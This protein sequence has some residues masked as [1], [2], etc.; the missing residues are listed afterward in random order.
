MNGY[1]MPKAQKSYNDARNL[2]KNPSEKDCELAIELLD[3]DVC[4][5]HLPKAVRDENYQLFSSA[6]VLRADIWH[7]LLTFNRDK[8]WNT[9][10][11]SRAWKQKCDKVLSRD[12]HKCRECGEPAEKVC[13]KRYDQLGREPLSDLVSRCKGCED[14][15]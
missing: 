6:R 1:S 15:P 8:Y 13:H 7:Y 5:E 14:T 2:F 10:L 3:K 11:E 9:Y 4:L 12:K